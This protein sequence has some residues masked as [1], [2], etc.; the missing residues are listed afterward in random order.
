M[1][2]SPFLSTLLWFAPL[3]VCLLAVQKSLT[4]RAYKIFNVVFTVV[5]SLAFFLLLKGGGISQFKKPKFLFYIALMSGTIWLFFLPKNESP[6]NPKASRALFA[7]HSDVLFV[8][9]LINGFITLA[10]N[11]MYQKTLTIPF[12]S[13]L[14]YAFIYTGYILLPIYL[15]F[16]IAFR[17]SAHKTLSALVWFES[18]RLWVQIIDVMAFTKTQSHIPTPP[19]MR[20]LMGWEQHPYNDW[21]WTPHR[22][23]FICAF[24][25]LFLIGLQVLIQWL[26]VEGKKFQ[27]RRLIAAQEAAAQAAKEL[28]TAKKASEDDELSHTLEVEPIDEDALASEEAADEKE[29]QSEE[30]P[31]K[32][33]SVD[34]GQLTHDEWGALA[35]FRTSHRKVLSGLFFLC[36]LICFGSVSFSKTMEEK[37]HAHLPLFERLHIDLRWWDKKDFKKQLKLRAKRFKKPKKSFYKR[38]VN[39]P[40]II[41]FAARSLGEDALRP[42]NMPKW[43]KAMA[44]TP[45]LFSPRH[46]GATKTKNLG[47]QSILHSVY[48]HRIDLF[49]KQK[50]WSLQQLRKF[51]YRLEVVFEESKKRNRHKTHK[52]FKRMGFHKVSGYHYKKRR[53]NKKLFGHLKKLFAKRYPTPKPPSTQ[54]VSTSKPTLLERI[55]AAQARPTKKTKQP[56]F[57]LIVADILPSKSLRKRRS[58]GH[59]RRTLRK[60]DARWTALW[61][62]HIKHYIKKDLALIWTGEHGWFQGRGPSTANNWFKNAGVPLAIFFPRQKRRGVM[63]SSHP[64][65]FPTLFN[66]MGVGP[67]QNPAPKFTDGE[68]INASYVARSL[69]RMHVISEPLPKTSGLGIMSYPYSFLL[70]WDKGLRMRL[71]STSAYDGFTAGLS[72]HFIVG[73]MKSKKTA[74]QAFTPGF[75]F[76]SDRPLQFQSN[77]PVT[78]SFAPCSKRRYRQR[79]SRKPV[80]VQYPVSG[81]IG[82][83]LEMVGYDLPKMAVPAGK[84]AKALITLKVLKPLGKWRLFTHLRSGGSWFLNKDGEVFT[85]YSPKRWK[86]GDIVSGWLSFT[87]PRQKYVTLHVGLWARGSGRQTAYS[88]GSSSDSIKM[89]TF[90][91]SNK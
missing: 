34:D 65:I 4:G 28:A 56:T 82:D 67:Y 16:W 58:C 25:F 3:L 86:K 79:K 48:P 18:L 30:K 40:D 59:Y 60:F 42:S 64:D 88:D 19:A 13:K 87:M 46:I 29:E 80:F 54:P 1:T 23:A 39:R 71:A 26:Y 9:L 61:H 51:G 85:R 57:L 68:P 12:S 70:K 91:A 5:I 37:L 73:R 2:F 49:K 11:I 36:F 72:E 21:A 53:T 62:K 45:V 81:R 33:A 44:S 31:E 47:I 8:Y 43:S 35:F 10:C 84:K 90:Y 27:Q 55:R 15:L 83:Y 50:P 22:F 6:P 78:A 52:L 69:D 24:I 76:W 38:A 32:A 63:S 41:L 7:K 20:W 66:L 17:F 89:L 74:L 75:Q 14:L 77:K